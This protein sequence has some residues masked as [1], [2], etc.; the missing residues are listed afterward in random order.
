M[1]NPNTLY[2]REE[3]A[4][5]QVSAYEDSAKT[6]PIFLTQQF[7]VI[8]GGHAE[9]A[10]EL[11]RPGNMEPAQVIGGIVTPADVTTE[12]PYGDG[13]APWVLPLFNSSGKG[14][15]VAKVEPRDGDGNPQAEGNL[16]WEGIL[17]TVTVPKRDSSTSAKTM[18]SIVFAPGEGIQV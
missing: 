6:K 10:T 15:V 5:I 2:F 12:V 17:K 14:W 1:A 11:V 3:T 16:Q 18:L 7:A 4:L 8:D 9:A 13:T